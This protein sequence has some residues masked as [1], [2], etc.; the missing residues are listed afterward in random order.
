[1]CSYCNGHDILKCV[2]QEFPYKA[3]FRGRIAAWEIYQA[4]AKTPVVSHGA[5][6]NMSLRV[7]FI[8]FKGPRDCSAREP[9]N[10]VTDPVH[11]RKFKQYDN[12]T[13]ESVNI[14]TIVE[15][16][17]VLLKFGNLYVNRIVCCYSFI[18]VSSKPSN[19]KYLVKKNIY[20]NQPSHSNKGSKA[21]GFD[22]C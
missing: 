19:I 9:A 1:M 18:D 16:M 17:Y 3:N 20:F 12:C 14:T 7:T 22:G 13:A 8:T 6:Q 21:K 4:K 11:G 5:S 2:F 15:Q 10:F